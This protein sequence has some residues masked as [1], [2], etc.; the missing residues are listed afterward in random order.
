MPSVALIAAFAGLTS[1]AAASP[2]EI[3]KRAGAF[4][5]DQVQ[6]GHSVRVGPAA[7]QKV[8]Q[9]YS[10]AVPTK[11]SAAA[12]AA[13]AAASGSV[14]A[15]PE[16]YDA[17]YLCPVSVGGTTLNLDFDTGSAD[18]YVDQYLYDA[19]QLQLLLTW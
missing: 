14:Q 8:Y 19:I 1:L 9:K 7:L 13:A 11:V 6:T 3:E 5:V 12:A 4:R 15:S 17:E 2:V 16:Q 10:K 18:L